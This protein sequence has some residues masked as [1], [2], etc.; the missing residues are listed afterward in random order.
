LCWHRVSSGFSGKVIRCF[1]NYA[2]GK[3]DTILTGAAG[4]V[5]MADDWCRATE[6]SGATITV[7]N[8]IGNAKMSRKSLILI[9]VVMMHAGLS[10]WGQ[11][12]EPGHS[13]FEPL[14]ELD[15]YTAGT[16]NGFFFSYDRLIWSAHSE[17]ATV[18]S[19]TANRRHVEIWGPGSDQN[20]PPIV[21]IPA[22][23]F[24]NPFTSP[25]VVMN[26]L[27][28][29]FSRPN[30]DMG[31]RFEFGV[32][33][34]GDEWFASILPPLDITQDQTVGIG[35][36][37]QQD[38]VGAPG[39]PG[40]NELPGGPLQAASPFGSVLILFDYEPFLMHGFLDVF[41]GPIPTAGVPGNVL[42]NDTN[43]D[44]ILDGDGFA[45]D[46]NG[47]LVHGPD[48]ADQAALD[49]V[50]DTFI[51]AIDFADL[52][53]LPTSWRTVSIRS[54]LDTTGVELMGAHRLQSGFVDRTS[55]QFLYG[56]RYLRYKDEFFVFGQGGVLGDSFWDTEIRNELVGPQLGLRWIRNHGRWGFTVDGRAFLA[57]NVQ[58]W[59]Q[60]VSIGEDLIPSQLNHPLYFSPTAAHHAKREFEFAPMGELKIIGSYQFSKGIAFNVGF[61][62]MFVDGIR[63]AATHVRYRLPDMGF[64]EGHRENIFL[65]GVNLGVTFAH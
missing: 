12:Y 49:G 20:Q 34:D 65:S 43:G 5:E 11:L 44:G 18:G 2:T 48:G 64:A 53:E 6:Q 60:D 7:P 56:V 30:F 29:I 24:A 23:V 1:L 41:E 14:I 4:A 57:L 39:V 8:R 21:F 26:G 37:G 47:N 9:A 27:N 42:R 19:D 10:A 55:L 58:D 32:R 61:N 45:D 36:T 62:G 59:E 13:Y 33:C 16:E 54:T 31:N 3:T 52:V 15:E 28:E 38:T 25:P 40:S 22:P 35:I 17:R 50:P 46:I 63:R 51:G